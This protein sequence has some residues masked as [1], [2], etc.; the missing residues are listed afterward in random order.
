MTINVAAT[1]TATSTRT[2]QARA[3]SF[4]EFSSLI[5]VSNE[6][7]DHVTKSTKWYT[8]NERQ[9]FRQ[10]LM[11]DVRQVSHEI[12]EL[13]PGGIMTPEQ[14]CGCLGIELFIN[15]AAA[16]NAE[17]ARRAHISAVLSEQRRQIYL[18]ICD[19]KELS[20]VSKRGSRGMRERARKLALG[21]AC[22]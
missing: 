21:Y 8:S 18:G 22:L 7:D 13:S 2:R 9:R 3:V 20:I 16:K 19:P 1:S 11:D 12:N 15:R 10:T 4:S 17:R 5:F 14:L 6:E